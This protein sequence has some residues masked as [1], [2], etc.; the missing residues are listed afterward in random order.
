[1]AKKGNGARKGG[2]YQR[3]I[4]KKL[5]LWA[6]EGKHDDIIWHTSGSGARATTRAKQGK[7][8]VNNYG[9]LMHTCEE[10]KPLFEHCVIELKNGYGKWAPLDCIDYGATMKTV[11][12]FDEFIEQVERDCSLAERRYPILIAKRDKRR[13]IIAI[14]KQLNMAI[15]L[16]YGKCQCK[17][18]HYVCNSDSANP[19]IYIIMALDEFLQWCPFEFFRQIG[20]KNA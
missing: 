11:Q 1:M 5:S 20:D 12:V 7:R 17:K 18:I 14:P 9:D 2:N 8:T 10:G 16:M 15:E 13:D 3:T 19:S 6:T 4:A